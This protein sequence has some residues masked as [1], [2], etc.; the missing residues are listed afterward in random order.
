MEYTRARN[1]AKSET[2]RAVRDYEKE[3]ARLAKRN[4]KAFYKFVNGKLKTRTRIV[5][6]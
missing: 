5:D 4:P 1:A 6:L 3:V 2:R